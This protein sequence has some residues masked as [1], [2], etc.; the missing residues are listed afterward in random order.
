MAGQAGT[1]TR[2]LHR[3]LMQFCFIME[4]SYRLFKQAV[5]PG[6]LPP[7]LL[8]TVCVALRPGP[9]PPEL[10][11]TVCVRASPRA[12]RALS[13]K[14]PAAGNAKKVRLGAASRVGRLERDP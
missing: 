6:P 8:P 11:P 3:S 12:S 2:L 7:E 9:L 14:E 13:S 10:L 5:R 1:F 4:H